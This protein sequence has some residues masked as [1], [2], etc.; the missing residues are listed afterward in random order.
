MTGFGEASG[1]NGRYAVSISL[2]SVNHRFLDLQIRLAEEHRGNEAVVRELIGRELVR[3][4]VEARIDLKP[5][6]EP[7]ARV[8]VNHEIVRGAAAAIRELAE[9]GL[10]TEGLTAG[11][12]LRLPAAFRVEVEGA[13][14]GTEDDALLAEVTRGA[15]ARLVGARE[16][17]GRNL[18]ELFVER[19]R[20]LDE[21]AAVF[22]A[23]RGTAR[24]ELAAALRKRLDETLQG[25]E[26]DPGRL[27]QEVALLVDRSDV[28]E[29]VDRLRSHLAHFREVI[30][31]A[32]AI[33]KRLDF[34]I[35]EIFRELNTL[36]S[37][38]RNAALTRAVL[39]AKVICE[40][41]R[42]QVQNVE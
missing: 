12:L 23:L 29:E 7:A 30:A 38:C 19:L 33:G 13:D 14:W 8:E 37:K 34:L 32:G 15:L 28:S 9:A 40:E 35:Q 16:V 27:A 20:K 24:E 39:D 5:A 3:G 42:E 1:D 26:I 41:M 18:A 21:L 36:G 11:D 31:D 6:T 2:R 25:A 10:V 4:R 17:E 22:D